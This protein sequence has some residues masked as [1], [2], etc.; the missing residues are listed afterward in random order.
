MILGPWAVSV[1]SPA[2]VFPHPKSGYATRLA[3][4][5]R[6]GSSGRT[7]VPKA[8]A[9]TVC[10]GSAHLKIDDTKAKTE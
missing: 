3:I 4:R 9:A 7:H 6:K 10:A 8:A 1:P 5:S 2:L